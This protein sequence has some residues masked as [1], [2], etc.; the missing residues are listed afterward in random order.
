MDVPDLSP[1]SSFWDSAENAVLLNPRHQDEAPALGSELRDSLGREGIKGHVVFATSG[2]S[3]DAKFACLSKS[4]LL[5]S[6]SMVN[7]HLRAGDEDT[8]LCA[9][10]VFHVGGFGI[11]ARAHLANG[12]LRVIESPWDAQAFA[13]SAEEIGATMSS[14]VPT[15]VFDLVKARVV[16]P[17]N[18][19]AVV[20]GGGALDTDLRSQALALGWP[21][22]ESFGMTEAGSQIAT[23]DLE[24][25]RS[26]SLRLPIL[27]G[28]SVRQN[29]DGL[30]EIRGRG[31]FSAYLVRG[32][33]Q[34]FEWN[35]PFD[36][37]GWFGTS[38]R[39]ALTEVDGNS[40]IE[41]MGRHDL[42]VKIR[43]E[44]VDVAR[45]QRDIDPT[46]R[47]IVVVAVPDSRTGFRLVGVVES[48]SRNVASATSRLV[49]HHAVAAP[50]E[51]V[52]LWAEVDSVP[53]SGLGK[54]LRLKL[55]EKVQKY[56]NLIQ[57][58]RPSKSC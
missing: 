36:D 38:D 25:M 8:W 57:S 19:R 43:G 10:P 42:V 45:V 14:L 16:C 55:M 53:R 18:L 54:P 33:D 35:Q 26:I 5:E 21:I 1:Q 20:V 6:A 46:E 32:D 13:D 50:C 28:W 37:D 12:K 27:P 58:T 48:G 29:D 23:R 11:C 7:H 15:Q 39:V 40:W 31:L 52:S 47:L 44:N 3:G 24:S 56:K 17:K 51:K 9:L 22:L 2:S 4:A 41:P 34:E 49:R 30:L